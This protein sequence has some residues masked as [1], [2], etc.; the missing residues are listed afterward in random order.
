MD[1][2]FGRGHLFKVDRKLFP[3]LY[4]FAALSNVGVTSSKS[5][6]KQRYWI[7]GTCS[8]LS[9]AIV[10]V[11]IGKVAMSGDGASGISRSPSREIPGDGLEARLRMHMERLTSHEMEGRLNSSSGY[12]RAA[13]YCAQFFA[14]IG[15]EPGWTG[16]EKKPVFF[17]PVQEGKID[18]VNVIAR[19][20]GSDSQLR[21]EYITLGAHLDHI[22]KTRLGKQYPGANDNASGCAVVLEVAKLLADNPPKR[23][24]IFVLFTAEEFGH[25][26]SQHF[27]KN[28][29]VPLDR[30]LMNI[31]LD[32]I[33]SRHRDYPGLFA[34]GPLS[35]RT[36]FESAGK[37]VFGT[38]VLLEDI[39][40]HLPAV[41]E[42]DTWSFLEAR[43]PA[44]IV[45]SGGFPEHHTLQDSVAL[46]DFDHLTRA[47]S[48]IISYV[49]ELA[50]GDERASI[51]GNGG[52]AN[53][54]QPIRS[55][56]NSTSSAADSRR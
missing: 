28:P 20:A 48:V 22:G 10:L 9:L 29:P 30:L 55:E 56:T 6:M 16:A 24:I 34:F 8:A 51:E 37:S 27:V 44:M 33:G 41:R 19:L 3:V 23:S 54:S 43:K 36:P 53:G 32:Q 46:M 26:G 31:N 42:S 11:V 15:I 2:G 38:W 7:A 17:Q 14:S 13:D 47:T 18:C 1:P 50:G 40:D 39:Q 25:I 12:R 35:Q 5:S 21:N 4:S 49:R 52:A 45:S